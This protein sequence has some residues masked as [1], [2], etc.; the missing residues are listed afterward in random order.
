MRGSRIRTPKSVARLRIPA[1][2]GMTVPRAAP[3][4]ERALEHE[5]R[6]EPDE[7]EP[8]GVVPGQDLLEI[9]DRESGEHDQGDD[10]LHGLELGGAVDRAAV[11]VGRHGQAILEEGDAPARH[12]DE[13]ERTIRELEM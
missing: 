4:L 6:A 10:L 1:F 9:D 12:D 11:A 8:D 13:P 7:T 5:E 3:S 2:V